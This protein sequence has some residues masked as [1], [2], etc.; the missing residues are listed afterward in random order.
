MGN[1]RLDSKSQGAL[2]PPG[3]A[4]LQH[5]R[6]FQKRKMIDLL[7]AA[8]SEEIDGILENAVGCTI[9]TEE[10]GRLALFDNEYGWERYRKAGIAV[11]DT[12]RGELWFRGRNVT[13]P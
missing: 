3:S 7:M 1:T 11:I 6:V 13:N 12:I 10:H 2:Y 4:G 8:K 9:T 5:E